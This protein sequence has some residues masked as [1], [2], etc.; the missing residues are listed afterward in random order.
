MHRALAFVT[1]MSLG[2]TTLPRASAAAEK[3]WQPVVMKRIAVGLSAIVPGAGGHGILAVPVTSNTAEPVWVTLKL[4]P[5]APATESV[6]QRTLDARANMVIQF[7]Q[8]AF[9]ADAEYVLSVAVFADSSSTDT[10]ES[11][12]TRAR[13]T[14][15]DMKA[16]DEYLKASTLPQTLKNIDKV[17][18][19][20][21]GSTLGGMFRMTPDDG[22]LTVD[23]SGINYEKK[24]ESIIIPAA[25]LR[26]VKM[27]GSDPKQTWVTVTY[28]RDGEKK[29]VSFKPNSSRGNT[30]ASQIFLAIQAAMPLAPAE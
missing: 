8:D 1:L 23:A 26:D 30:T 25:A 7:P 9:V 20:T 18:K 12:S 6:V 16:L 19:V 13:Y 28:E 21:A 4:R 2:F 11:G 29:S 17:D 14:K 5:P 10:L 22:T 15:K 24:K 27:N 3:N